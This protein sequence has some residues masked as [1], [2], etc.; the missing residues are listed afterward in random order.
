MI[1][2][3]RQGL[4]QLPRFVVNL[5]GLALDNLPDACQRHACLETDALKIITLID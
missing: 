5:Q 2:A 4:K 1:E 3:L